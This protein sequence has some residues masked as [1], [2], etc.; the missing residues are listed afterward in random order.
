MDNQ[1]IILA[2]VAVYLAI[3]LVVGIYAVRRTTSAEDF[4]VAGRSL[5]LWLCSATVMATWI[6]GGTLMG[7]SGEAYRGGVLAV[8]ADPYGAAVGLILVG[9]LVVRII[10]RLKL[11]TIVDFIENRF[12]GAA[13][14]F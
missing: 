4:I 11:L 12:G 10:R 1:H 6:G 13:A 9:L 3:M 7:A 5:P 14:M 8:I 2:G